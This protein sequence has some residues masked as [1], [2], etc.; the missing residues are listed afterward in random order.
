MILSGLCLW[1]VYATVGI[2]TQMLP[3]LMAGYWMVSSISVG[4][5][6]A[7]LQRMRVPLSVTVPLTVMFRFFPTAVSQRRA[8]RDAMSMRGVRWG[9][10]KAVQMVEYRVIPLMAGAIRSADELSPGRGHPWSGV[11]SEPYEHRAHR[12][13]RV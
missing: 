11:G 13:L 8:I 2:L 6:A 9:G 1:L 10:G 5:L 4:E 12:I 3:G 7:A